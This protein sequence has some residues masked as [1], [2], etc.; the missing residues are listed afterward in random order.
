MKTSKILIILA[1][2][3]IAQLYLASALTISSVNSNPTEIQPGNTVALD[4]TIKNDLND[5][6]SNVVVNLN[7]NNP[8]N[9]LPFAPY[10]SSNQRTIDS[11]SSG[12]HETVHFSLIALSDA[13]SGTYTIP[14]T[15][16]YLDG[17][18]LGTDSSGVVSVT[19]NAKPQIS[20][21]SEQSS[22]IK[23]TSG[24]VTLMIVNSGLG[25]SKFLTINVNSV[26]GI[27]FTSP[28]SVYIGNIDS[29]DFD[30]ADF[31]VFV[32]ANAPS[33]INLP[34]QVTYTDSTNNQITE[35]QIILVK[36]YTTQEAKNLGLISGN[37]T[38]LIIILIILVIIGFFIYRS[39]RKRRRNNKRNGQ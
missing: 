1:A 23:G 9:P 27:T 7:L 10:Q 25:G 19:I 28:N 8:T 6:V 26:Q 22:L 39:V 2:I 3:F 5:D 13:A 15:I 35:N 4:L 36:T 30:S 16:T 33:T 18:I 29:N 14:V 24:K 38:V 37:N 11:L 32:N 31:N 34:V 17:N 12:D 21:S 20:V